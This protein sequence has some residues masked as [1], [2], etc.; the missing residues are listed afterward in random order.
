MRGIEA[1]L[2]I[3][4]NRKIFFCN[5]R[6]DILSCVDIDGVTLSAVPFLR[7]GGGS[8]QAEKPFVILISDV[9]PQGT[10]ICRQFF[11]LVIDDSVT[12]QSRLISIFNVEIRIDDGN[13]FGAAWFTLFYWSMFID[14][15]H[16]VYLIIA[17]C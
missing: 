17:G 8:S 7:L 9:I 13:G 6:K 16:L 11:V 10:P 14:Q 3:S 1:Q 15:I 12:L 5:N 2:C 4:N